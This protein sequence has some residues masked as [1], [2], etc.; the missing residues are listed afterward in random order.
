MP[1]RLW[2]VPEGEPS[3]PLLLM[4]YGSFWVQKL[5]AANAMA[6]MEG[7]RRRTFHATVATQYGATH[8]FAWLAPCILERSK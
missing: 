4:Q 6:L 1:L 3:M 5:P 7:S 2:K 8:Q